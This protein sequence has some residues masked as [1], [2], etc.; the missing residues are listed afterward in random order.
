MHAVA[1]GENLSLLKPPI[2]C[3]LK[4][5]ANVAKLQTSPTQDESALYSSHDLDV[6]HLGDDQKVV[7]LQ[8]TICKG[9]TQKYSQ[10]IA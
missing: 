9:A 1:I 10:N 2:V 8:I 4:S 7:V 6:C 5:R 3:V